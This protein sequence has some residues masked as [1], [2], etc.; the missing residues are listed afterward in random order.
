MTNYCLFTI[1]HPNAKRIYIRG[2]VDLTEPINEYEKII[3]FYE[4]SDLKNSLPKNPYGKETEDYTL[5]KELLNSIE[6]RF[7]DIGDELVFAD[8]IDEEHQE[9]HNHFVDEDFIID[10][11][12]ITIES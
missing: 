7:E 4:G 2:V 9:W 3:E 1:T 5:F 11:E 10:M 8:F 12:K 6:S